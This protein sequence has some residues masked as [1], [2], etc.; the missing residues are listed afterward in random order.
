MNEILVI[1]PNGSRGSAYRIHGGI[2]YGDGAFYPVERGDYIFELS[3]EGKLQAFQ[4]DSIDGLI[5]TGT[6]HYAPF[7][8]PLKRAAFWFWE[9]VGGNF[10]DG[11]GRE[12]TKGMRRRL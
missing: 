3:G 7:S 1:N 4:V 11:P 12:I 8:G 9:Q 10:Q 5:A 2:G 6:L